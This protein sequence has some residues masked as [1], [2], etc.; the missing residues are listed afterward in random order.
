MSL[1]PTLISPIE[2][3]DQS[4]LRERTF[5][6]EAL[7]NEVRSLISDFE[8]PEYIAT[9]LRERYTLDEEQQYNVSRFI[10]EIVMGLIPP[11]FAPSR[12]SEL[13]GEPLQ[14]CRVI[15]DDLDRDLLQPNKLAFTMFLE[16][17]SEPEVIVN[18]IGKEGLRYKTIGDLMRDLEPLNSQERKAFLAQA[19]PFNRVLV[20][21]AL[22]NLKITGESTTFSQLLQREVNDFSEN[23]WVDVIRSEPDALLD[24]SV[25]RN[26]SETPLGAFLAGKTE[27]PSL[28]LLSQISILPQPRQNLLVSSRSKNILADLVDKNL[29]PGTHLFACL[30]MVALLVLGEI[31]PGQIDPILIKLGVQAGGASV[32]RDSLIELIPPATIQQSFAPLPPLRTSKPVPVPPPPNRTTIDL[33]DKKLTP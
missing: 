25:V 13:L 5:S 7:P 22:A 6:I 12:L 17:T 15:I 21:R 11:A 31:K 30:K 33:R 23:D 8:A 19:K 28:D 2:T 1:L 10:M 4:K 27:T 20:L 18:S 29:L 16:G 3:L 26:L 14:T 24:P 9:V 32:I